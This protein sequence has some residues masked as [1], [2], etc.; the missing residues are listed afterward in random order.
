MVFTR[1]ERGGGGQN[2]YRGSIKY[3]D[4]WKLDFFGGEH[5]IEYTD[6]EL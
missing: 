1:G 2:G 4:K 3:G 6:V 5:A